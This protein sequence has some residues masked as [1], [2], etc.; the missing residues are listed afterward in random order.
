MYINKGNTI[1]IYKKIFEENDKLLPPLIAKLD[2]LR[3][4]QN[5]NIIMIGRL[6]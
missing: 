4:K 3:I 5:S 6:R 2:E 1:D